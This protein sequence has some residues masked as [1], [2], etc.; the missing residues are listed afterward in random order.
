MIKT[1]SFA[2]PR[3]SKPASGSSHRASASSPRARRAA[4]EA[5]TLFDVSP[6]VSPSAKQTVVPAKTARVVPE[7]AAR[8][9]ADSAPK[10]LKSR[11]KPVSEIKQTPVE[12]VA[13]EVV[14][15][16]SAA[17]KPQQKSVVSQSVV[18]EAD[19]PEV[20]SSQTKSAPKKTRVKRAIVPGNLAEQYG[21]KVSRRVESGQVDAPEVDAPK[22]RLTKVEREARNQLLRVDEGLLERLARVAAIVPAKKAL[23]PRGWRFDCGRCGAVSHFETPVELCA[24]GAIAV[25]E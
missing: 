13:P 14:S 3:G 23:K 22:K 8:N 18:P 11:V 16:S 2:P 5:P 24:C 6:F 21:V 19:A 7:E 15:S 4:P 25:K 12:V 1:V 10:R 17:K 9:G 20:T